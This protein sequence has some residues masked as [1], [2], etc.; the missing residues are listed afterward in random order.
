[1]TGA[2]FIGFAW[3]ALSRQRRRTFLSLIGVTVG[4]AAVIL[5]TAL[6]EG[7]RI[8]V[9][10]QFEALGKNLIIVMPGKNETTGFSGVGGAP[11]DLTLEDA[12]A[13]AR[14]V[15][16]IREL[17]PVTIGES[18]IAHQE[19]RRRSTVL[20]TTE[21]M[22][23]I[24]GLRVSMGRFL[25][26]GAM[27]RGDAV[28]VL[29]ADIASELFGNTFPVGKVVRIGD[30]RTRVI[31]VL[32]S[33]GTQM[34]LDLDEVVIIPVASGMRLYN[35]T[36]LFRIMASARHHGDLEVVRR[37]ITEVLTDR[38]EE[39]DFTCISE[40]SVAGAFSQILTALTAALG[41]I[42]AISLS[43]AG[44]GIMNLMLVSVSERT[45]EVGLLKALGATRFQI[46]GVFLTEAILLTTGGAILGVCLGWLLVQVLVAVYPTLPA[47]PP[48]WAIAMVVATAFATGIFFGLL[49]AR[50][51]TDLDPVASLA[52]R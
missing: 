50:R 27:D 15:T 13:L 35:R 32:E 11:N 25:P 9:S 34:G 48:L 16:Q 30:W 39:E 12:E 40:D 45:P 42:A 6:G 51:A 28:A 52:R 17:A 14:Q 41:G 43:V 7:A 18:L 23:S 49:P 10:Q 2:D 8:Y 22:K 38:H 1:M 3:T 19:R 20:G 29:G 26:E 36:S 33:Q 24:R 37:R 44:I 46:L 4:V 21:A 31:G 47:T 5:L